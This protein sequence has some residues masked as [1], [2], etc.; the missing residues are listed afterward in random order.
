MENNYIKLNNNS[1]ISVEE[2]NGSILRSIMPNANEPI[3]KK[4]VDV[5]LNDCL[6]YMVQKAKDKCYYCLYRVPTIHAELGNIDVQSVITHLHQNLSKRKD[7]KVYLAEKDSDTLFI[8]W[9]K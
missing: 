8:S 6:R 3:R 7:I 5:I 1:V 4:V 9:E 2:L